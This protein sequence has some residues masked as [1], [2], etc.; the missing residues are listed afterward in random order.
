MAF[1]RMA[2]WG[3]IFERF[4]VFFFTPLLPLLSF[5]NEGWVRKKSSSR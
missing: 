1:G 2:G 4:F 3:I 5:E